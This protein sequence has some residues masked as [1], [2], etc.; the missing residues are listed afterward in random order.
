MLDDTTQG[1]SPEGGFDI[2]Q[3]L[4]PSQGDQG[5]GSQ[6]DPSTSTPGG[7]SSE[8]KFRFGGKEWQSQ[9]AAEE[10]FNKLSG[11]YGDVQG[12][13]NKLKAAL[14]DGYDISE[15]MKDPQMAEILPKLGIQVA[16][17][18]A[19]ERESREQQPQDY[20]GLAAQI[21]Q[22]RA[23]FALEREEAKFSKKLGRDLTDKEHNAT[24]SVIEK[25]PS[26][27]YEEA[28]KVAHHDEL[29][30]QAAQKAGRAPVNPGR[31][32]PPPSFA[33]GKPLNLNKP[34]HAMSKEEARE[35]MK[36]DVR[37]M[38]GRGG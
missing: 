12:T 34:V 19:E 33:A 1:G 16:A 30:K 8:T 11:R 20:Q 32:K 17:E 4:S 2:N 22:D 9:K 36:A 27:T 6:V 24:M 18:R 26:L 35:A 13:L 3:V 10:H 29:L 15:L 28:F 7:Q 31:P 14:A 25:A 37:E 38:M 23:A 5:A 21:R